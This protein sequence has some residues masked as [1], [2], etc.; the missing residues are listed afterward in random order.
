MKFW[1]QCFQDGRESV[2]SNPCSGRPSTSRT[3]ENVECIPAAI[4]ENQRLAV[5][6][7][8]EDLGIPQTIISEIL[9]EYLG[10]KRVAAKF[11][12]WLLSQ[13]RKEFHTL[14]TQDMLEPL[15]KTQIFSKRS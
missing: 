13:E 6:E 8:E 4:N 3:P 5:R 7:L 1:Y 12:P 14:V 15:T 11:V 2:D 9:M 10:K